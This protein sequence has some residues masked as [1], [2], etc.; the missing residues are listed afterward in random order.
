MAASS[1]GGFSVSSRN[2]P[3]FRFQAGLAAAPAEKA[4]AGSTQHLCRIHRSASLS[5][6]PVTTSVAT[7]TPVAFH[8]APA[9]NACSDHT[10]ACVPL[11]QPMRPFR[12]AWMILESRRVPEEGLRRRPQLLVGGVARGFQRGHMPVHE[13][14]I[15]AGFGLTRVKKVV[16]EEEWRLFGRIR[17]EEVRNSAGK[18]PRLE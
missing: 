18:I 11:R 4:G 17:E 6:P 10:A 1:R 5:R 15:L 8:P 3:F 9:A 2:R 13:D 12:A 16:I 14:S 7:T